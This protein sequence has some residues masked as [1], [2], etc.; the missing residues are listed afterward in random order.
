MA[1]DQLC[2]KCN[3]LG[4]I[5]PPNSSSP[6]TFTNMRM[7]RR[8]QELDP[9]CKLCRLISQIIDVDPNL[10]SSLQHGGD[11]YLRNAMGFGN[12]PPNFIQLMSG[13]KTSKFSIQ[14]SI[15]LIEESD[16]SSSEIKWTGRRV[17]LWLDITLI[18]YWLSACDHLHQ[19]TCALPQPKKSLPPEF[20]LIDVENN[21]VVLAPSKCDYLALSYVWGKITQP[22]LSKASKDTWSK[23]QALASF[24]LPRTIQ[25][26]IILTLKLRHRYLWVDSLCIVQD[27]E[28]HRMEQINN[29]HIIYSNALLTIVAAAGDDCEYGLPGMSRARSSWPDAANIGEIPYRPILTE[30]LSEFHNSNWNT[31]AWTLQEKLLSRRTLVLTESIALF[32]CH[33]SLWREDRYIYRPQEGS[34]ESLPAEG[35]LSNKSTLW[36]VLNLVKAN[37]NL[38]HGAPVDIALT[39]SRLLEAYVYRNV[40]K[41]E[42]F[43]HAFS[44]ICNLL[45]DTLGDSYYGFPQHLFHKALCWRTKTPRTRRLPF[46]S[47][48]WAGWDF[49]IP[50]NGPEHSML[51]RGAPFLS[52]FR[53]LGGR[54]TLFSQPDTMQQYALHPHFSQA[55]DETESKMELIGASLD[56]KSH[57]IGFQTSS[58]RLSLKHYP[59][60]DS[61]AQSGWVVYTICDPNERTGRQLTK[62][63]L[64]VG[65]TNREWA[66]L[67]ST[68]QEFVVVGYLPSVQIGFLGPRPT[69]TRP[70]YILML[71]ERR[72]GIAY[73]VQVTDPISCDDWWT[74]KPKAELIVLG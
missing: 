13:S 51:L 48:S 34:D 38:V 15:P 9:Q 65:P 12:P 14:P 19:R 74:V 72:G 70:E 24:I 45:S 10:R 4:L 22:T 23:D 68:T 28:L 36:P 71:V 52:I 54:C 53:L 17:D 25:D 20:R 40:T 5:Q 41:A 61:I 60:S 21:C 39:F 30:P 32:W 35:P 29:M 11:F 46:P 37:N 64:Q 2:S 49:D 3:A 26:A 66:L 59:H 42:D 69:L 43:L 67:N 16:S 50:A 1:P 55:I 62:I 44:G 73:R 31:R 18:G 47:W 56:F 63:Y 27:D 33:N 57:F 6:A 7:A 58:A 8:I